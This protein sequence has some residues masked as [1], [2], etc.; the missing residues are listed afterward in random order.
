MKKLTELVFVLDRS[1][2]MHALESE[3]IKGFNTMLSNQKEIHAA[4]YVTTVLFNDKLK[5][6]HDGEKLFEVF[7]MRKGDFRV[8]GTTALLDAVG[9]T[10]DKIEKRIESGFQTL[11]SRNVLFVIITDGRE[12]ASKLYTLEKIIKKITKLQK[13]YGWEFIFL[14]ANIDA[15]QAAADIGIQADHAADYSADEQGTMLNF[16]S[17][18]MAAA[19]MRL[20]NIQTKESLDAVR[21]YSKRRNH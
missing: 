19:G 17:V 1:G 5:F 14:G 18:S 12:N 6:L 7:P 9:L 16:E 2:S 4:T 21:D 15:I 11:D 13:K 3:T 8:G 10:I 20:G